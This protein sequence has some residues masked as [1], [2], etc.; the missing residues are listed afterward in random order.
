MIKMPFTL[1]DRVTSLSSFKVMDVMQAAQELE[2]QGRDIIHMEVGEPRF[3]LPEPLLKAAHQAL[4]KYPLGYTSACGIR[5]LRE[6]IADYYLQHH[7]LRIS[8]DRIIV[9]TGSSAALGLL[10]DLLFNPGDGVMLTDPGYPCNPNF[11]RRGRLQPQLIP[12]TESSHFQLTEALVKGFWCAYTRGVIIASPANPTGEIIDA[13]ELAA[14]CRFVTSHN[15]AL[16]A[17]EL[18]HGLTYSPSPPATAL[19]LSDNAFVINGFS[20]YYG[21]T[22]W[23]LGWLVAPDFCVERLT[24]MIQNFYI[25]SPTL[26]QY[27]ALAALDS[28]NQHIFQ[29]RR[30]EFRERRDYLVHALR[31]LGFGIQHVPEGAFYLYTDISAFSDD[32]ETFCNNLLFEHAIACTPGTD[33]GQNRASQYVRFSYTEPLPRLKQAVERLARFLATSP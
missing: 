28:D 15:G 19:A 16:I 30:D 13:A 17:D 2:Q 32:S 18:Y 8:P 25:S 24:A 12:V 6:A 26:S 7:Q 29:Q 1:A 11:L 31:D 27:V 22:G 21:L 14:I 4:E 23:R 33:F 5:P 3:E 9:T 10:C 20:K